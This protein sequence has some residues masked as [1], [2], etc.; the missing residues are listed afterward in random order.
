MTLAPILTLIPDPSP[1]FPNGSTPLQSLDHALPYPRTDRS[2]GLRLVQIC[3]F[4]TTSTLVFRIH[5][6]FQCTMYII[7]T[8]VAY[9]IDECD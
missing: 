4:L 9:S 6:Q 1:T 3:L 7:G 5:N 8:R 2:H